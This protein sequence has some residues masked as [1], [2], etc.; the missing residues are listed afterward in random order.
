MSK[1]AADKASIQEELDVFSE[2]LKKNGLKM[3]RQRQVVV[4]SFLEAGGHI[5][6][7]E[8][9]GL[10]RKRDRK[11][12]Q[13]TVFRTL[14]TLAE[15]GLAKEIVLHDGR[16]R[17][18]HTYRRPHHH[19][20]VCIECEKTIEFLSLESERIQEEITSQY[21]FKPVRHN[22]QIFGVCPDCQEKKKSETNVVDSDLVFAR[23]ALKIAIATEERG[24]NFYQTASQIVTH[25]STRTTFLKMLDEEK[26]HL[27]RLQERWDQLMGKD[28]RLL[29][30]PV[31]LHFDYEK[32]N[33]IFPSRSEAR[34]KLKTNLKETEA[35]KLAMK[36]EKE[37]WQFFDG[38]AKRFNDT[39]G[40]DIFLKFAAE[41][42]EHYT[43][44]KSEL[45]R[46]TGGGGGGNGG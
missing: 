13:V 29:D 46:L 19:H 15:C 10:A 8:L 11:L 33:Q 22:L 3:T 41:E 18:E 28:P 31:F 2:Y 43:I 9:Y 14:K 32:L 42:E 20:V 34:E 5:T 44:I 27:S 21:G 39:R 45:D 7:E 25:K 38:Y 24:I 40:R 36:M 16:T 30:A 4:E 12:G 6:T 17:F 35:L 26:E 1:P 23:D 37:A